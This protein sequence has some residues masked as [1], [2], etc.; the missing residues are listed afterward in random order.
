MDKVQELAFLTELRDLLKKH[1]AILIVGE[2][3]YGF[4]G[5]EQDYSHHVEVQFPHLHTLRLG[6]YYDLQTCEEQIATLVK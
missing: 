1:D 4:G 6:S 2:E 5:Y 3:A